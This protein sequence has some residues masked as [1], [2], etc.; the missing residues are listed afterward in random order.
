M[1]L[2]DRRGRGSAMGYRSCH[3]FRGYSALPGSGAFL[4]CMP[5]LGMLTSLGA[6][7]PMDSVSS[8]SK[9]LSWI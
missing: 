8:Q 2:L 1:E 6:A 5:S 3:L 7:L 9:H 4:G